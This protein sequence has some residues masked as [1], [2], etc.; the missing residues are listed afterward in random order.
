MIASCACE[1]ACVLG[2]SP[3]WQPD[4][5]R[6]YWVDILEGRIHALHT[7]QGI[8][9]SWDIG[10]QVGSIA[11]AGQDRLVAALEVGFALIDFRGAMPAIELLGDPEADQPGNRFNDGACDW[12]G[13]FWAG[14]MDR[15]GKA[16]TGSF[17][18]LGPDR[19]WLLADT[20]YAICN[21][22]AFAPDGKS[23]YLT[24]SAAGIVW[25]C[26][27][28]QD[29]L[30]AKQVF[31]AFSGPEGVPDGMAVDV[32]GGV[33][34]ARWGTGQV[35][36]YDPD[37]GEIATIE[38]PVSHPTKCAFGGPDMRTL[39]ITSARTEISSNELRFQPLA[40]SVFSIETDVQGWLLPGW[41]ERTI[42]RT[43]SR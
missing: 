24:D 1:V 26:R 38:L 20:G 31:R 5:Q 36:R 33:W 9:Q 40:G 41:E 6:L 19:S 13:R 30:A 42:P 23:A 34:I 29:G 22:P 3:V 4:G 18:I 12:W 17:W 8:H 39:Y 43:S 37:G 35:T 7:Q 32:D 21:G 15:G 2:E 28:D 25:K 10:H 16:H 14:S 27:V 11:L